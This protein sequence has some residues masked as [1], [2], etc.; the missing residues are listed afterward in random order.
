MDDV[1]K[2]D[3]DGRHPSTADGVEAV[4]P[5]HDFDRRRRLAL[6]RR[7]LREKWNV[8]AHYVKPMM[9]RQIAVALDPKSSNDDARNAYRAVA[10]VEFGGRA[11]AL[12]EEES[13]LGILESETPKQPIT[14]NVVNVINQLRASKVSEEELRELISDYET[15]SE[16]G[17]NG[18]ASHR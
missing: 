2:V 13:D 10:A 5:E 12:R 9:D 4:A 8:P 6:E 14:I 16:P 7:A 3:G 15:K 1:D 11:I 17:T 18:T